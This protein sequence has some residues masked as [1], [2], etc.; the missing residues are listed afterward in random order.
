MTHIIVTQ[1]KFK[2][3]QGE[4]VTHKVETEFTGETL[5]FVRRAPASEESVRQAKELLTDERAA[6]HLRENNRLLHI[7]EGEY[8]VL[9]YAYPSPSPIEFNGQIEWTLMSDRIWRGDYD[10]TLD[11]HPHSLSKDEEVR[12]NKALVKMRTQE[13]AEKTRR[14]RE[15][16]LAI[17]GFIDNLTIFGNRMFDLA[18]WILQEQFPEYETMTH[19]SNTMTMFNNLVANLFVGYKVVADLDHE[20]WSSR[21]TAHFTFT[22]KNIHVSLKSDDEIRHHTESSR[23]YQISQKIKAYKEYSYKSGPLLDNEH[24]K[25]HDSIDALEDELNMLLNNMPA[26]SESNP[27]TPAQPG[28]EANLESTM[29]GPKHRPAIVYV[30]NGA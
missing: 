9:E 29:P 2:G 19:K 5:Y 12:S 4:L 3:T 30:S 7:Y 17:Y 11:K 10:T 22:P 16:L 14:F 26:D 28:L 20:A 27:D 6:E 24:L 15:D 25:M 13:A 18:V 23:V 21:H 8:E 1:G